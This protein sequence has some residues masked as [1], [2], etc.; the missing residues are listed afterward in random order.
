MSKKLTY[1]ELE[2]KVKALEQ[3]VIKRKQLEEQIVEENY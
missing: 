2:Q 1:K 3:D